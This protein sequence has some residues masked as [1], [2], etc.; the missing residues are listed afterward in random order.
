MQVGIKVRDLA[1]EKRKLLKQI[2]RKRLNTLFYGAILV[3]TLFTITDENDVLLHAL[4]DYAIVILSI[5]A[6]GLILA[7]RKRTTLTDLEKLNN[8]LAV[9]AVVLV[10]FVGF[11]FT[12]EI[13]DVTDFAND[14]GQ[15]L[16]LALV[17]INRFT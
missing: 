7:M 2:A 12:Q 8:V 3:A 14:P 10:A 6:L 13:S 16:F 11:A 5:V 4:D 9:M 15:L 1:P 17:I